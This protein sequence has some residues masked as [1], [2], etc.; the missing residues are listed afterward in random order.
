[1]LLQASFALPH[2]WSREGVAA[3][4]ATPAVI[5]CWLLVL[6]G[7]LWFIGVMWIPMGSC[8]PEW[9]DL[10][11]GQ[12]CGLRRLWHFWCGLGPAEV[13]GRFPRGWWV[14][15]ILGIVSRYQFYCYIGTLTLLWSGWLRNPA[16]ALLG[17]GWLGLHR[18]WVLPVTAWPACRLRWTALIGRLPM[19]T[20]G[21]RGS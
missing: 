5:I 15:S 11:G 17:P 9:A 8:S 14:H 12:W 13:R 1:V 6:T 18:G 10:V 19:G 3:R 2:W 16:G 21:S 4:F 7:S 20:H